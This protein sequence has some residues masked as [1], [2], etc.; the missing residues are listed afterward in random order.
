MTA[1]MLLSLCRHEERESLPMD[2]DIAI[3]EEKDKNLLKSSYKR[4][5]N[6]TDGVGA[7]LWHN[8][9]S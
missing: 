1:S 9:Y 3:C 8:L 6:L 7:K 5:G 4:I 2:Y